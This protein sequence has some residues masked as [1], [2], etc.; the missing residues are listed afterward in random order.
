MAL[1]KFLRAM[2]LVSVSSIMSWFLSYLAA[3]A[4]LLLTIMALMGF[5]EVAYRYSPFRA[6]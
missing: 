1:S 2:G 5:P 6:Q 4:M 3:P